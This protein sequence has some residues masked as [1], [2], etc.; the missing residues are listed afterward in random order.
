MMTKRCGTWMI[1]T[2]QPHLPRQL[3]ARVRGKGGAPAV[4]QHAPHGRRHE[5]VGDSL[6]NRVG[7]HSRADIYVQ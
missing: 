3:V 1:H 2:L 4:L 7:G 5:G 6:R